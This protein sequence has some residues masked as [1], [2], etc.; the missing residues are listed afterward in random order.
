MKTGAVS[1]CECCGQENRGLSVI[2]LE[3]PVAAAWRGS[4]FASKWETEECCCFFL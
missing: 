2:D 4:H 3:K 1:R